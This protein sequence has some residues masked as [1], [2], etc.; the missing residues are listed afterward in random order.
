MLKEI[1]KE[2]LEH[3][4][5]IVELLEVFEFAH[6]KLSCKAIRFA[7]DEHGG[8]NISIRLDNNDYLNV[9][10]FAKNVH[11]DIFSYIMQEK[12]VTFRE[13]LQQTKNILGLDNNWRPPQ[14]RALFGGL[15]ER[16][17]KPSKDID[18]KTYD[19]SVLDKYEQCGNVR[20]LRDG[21]S[22]EAQKFW[23][24]RFSAEDNSII[25]P[26]YNE[27]GD[28][29]GAKAR[30]NREPREEELKYYY[31][32]ATYASQTLWGYANNYQYLYGNDVF[33]VE[34]EK[35]VMQAWDFGVR[36]IVGLASN[37]L[38]EKQAKLLLQLQPKRII[39]AMDEGL[40]FALIKRNAD[41]I[42]EV[43]SLLMP[44]I[45]YWDWTQNLDA[46]SKDSPTDNGKEVFEEIV[47]EQLV[48]IY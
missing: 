44:E 3:P 37:S 2:L 41:T 34:S 18:V 28:L 11:L 32:I 24:I 40:D 20:F 45:W 15:Y 47:N 21:I 13:V 38:S 1:K 19:E 9:V 16:I 39:L 17:L 6:I 35:S 31:P 14:R 48:R 46:N 8:Q 4:K 30:I 36:N 5:H 7:R 25:I 42:K 22:L 29:I 26:V 43:G 12:N 10:D 33:V 27:Y 23:N